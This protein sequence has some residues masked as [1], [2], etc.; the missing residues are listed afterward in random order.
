MG[1]LDTRGFM[2]TA[3]RSFDVADRYFT[4][5][6]DRE[7]QRLRDAKHDERFDQQMALRHAQDQRAQQAHEDKYGVDG[8]GGW[9]A[10]QRQREGELHEKN[11]SLREAQIANTK[12]GQR[13]S[14]YLFQQDKR[15]AYIQENAPLLET[16]WQRYQKT[17]DIDEVFESEHIKGGVYD[18]RRWFDEE[19]DGAAG[20]LEQRIPL[21]MKGEIGLDDQELNTA[22]SVFYR[23]NLIASVG[24][25]DPKTGKVI[26]DVQWGGATFSRDIN[27]DMAGD[28]PGLVVHASMQYEGEDGRHM[29]PIT[30][31]RST[32]PGDKVKV[33]PLDAVMQDITG[34][35]KMR[36]QAQLSPAYQSLFRGKETK[37]QAVEQKA[38]EKEYRSAVLEL[39]KERR[40]TKRESLEQTPEAFDLI[41]K[42]FDEQRTFLDTMY[43]KGQLPRQSS[44]ADAYEQWAAD[45]PNKQ[46]FLNALKERGQD[47]TQ[48][49]VQTLERAYTNEVNKQKAANA[50]AI[51]GKIRTE[52]AKR[53]ASR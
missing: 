43:K 1:K 14:D 18:P 30:E 16:A 41:D 42:E 33:I 51:A 26:K 25:T 28:Q 27:P 47:F 50:E 52:N 11:L 39:E 24:Q 46:G 35:L 10:V 19:L 6:E 21:V 8:E 48:F 38:M 53:Y 36:R 4:R 45:D 15:K 20:T 32:D 44:P 49:D 5:Q 37:A 2:D 13:R 12:S 40:K 29:R 9:L 22:L 3:L 7:Y 31:G 34:Q 17:G 23:S